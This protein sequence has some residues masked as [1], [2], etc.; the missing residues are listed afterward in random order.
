VKALTPELLLSVFS[1]RPAYAKYEADYKTMAHDLSK[2]L[3]RGIEP[4]TLGFAEDDH[5][6][7]KPWGFDI[8]AIDR[9]VQMW[10]GDTDEFIPV[11]HAQWFAKHVRNI[12]LHILEGQDHI[13]IMVEH[14][15]Q[16]LEGALS[17][18]KATAL[19]NDFPN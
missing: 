13:S 1:N 5:S 7:L 10:I 17:L 2:S 16:I 11:S 3:M 18:L 4:D 9:P 15:D 6:W 8:G 14:F 19:G 12:D